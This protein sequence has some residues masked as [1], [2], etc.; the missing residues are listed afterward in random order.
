MPLRTNARQ[1][2]EEL[3]KLMLQLPEDLTDAD[4]GALLRILSESER[5]DDAGGD[6]R[7]RRLAGERQRLAVSIECV[8]LDQIDEV[9]VKEPN[10]SADPGDADRIRA[11][12]QKPK[13]G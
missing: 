11:T 9:E 8:D 10:Q 12:P 5:L 7:F 2:L 6:F 4:F 1:A 3:A 13:C